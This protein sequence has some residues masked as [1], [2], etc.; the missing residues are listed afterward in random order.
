MFATIIGLL[1][2][3][4]LTVILGAVTRKAWRAGRPW[5]KWSG[6][7]LAGLFTFVFAV[8]TVLGAIGTY[9]L[10]RAYNVALPHVAIDGT[11][12]QIARGEHLAD[13]LCA[14]CHSLS[15]ELPLSGGKNLSE[16]AGLPLGDIYASNIT[17]AGD[18]KDMSDAEL[19]R[20]LRTGVNEEGRATTMTAIVGVRALDDEDVSALIAF[21]RQSTPVE[22][23]TP[24]FK[25]SILMALF[26][27]AGLIPLDVP[28]AVNPVAA[29]PKAANSDYGQYVLAFMDCQSCHG[30]NLDGNVPPPYPPAPD[31]RPVLSTLSFEQFFDLIQANASAAQLG[32]V[33]PWK[34]IA[35]LDEVELEALY[36]YLHEA[37]SK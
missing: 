12:E 35:R 5:I 37:A 13:V 8:L 16:D 26:A 4:L 2:L 22:R 18:I 30:V 36:Q 29:P 1:F 31:I 23:E 34:F 14:T 15:G 28:A 7:L 10:F 24:E 17:P 11:P 21:M 19:F 20:L 9:K 3:I 33:M 32:E 25:P 6:A 27:G